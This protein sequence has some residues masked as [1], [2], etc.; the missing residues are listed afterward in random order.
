MKKAVVFGGC[1]EVGKSVVRDLVENSDFNPIVI[2]DVRERVARPFIKELGI[3][4]VTFQKANA[5]DHASMVEAMAGARVIVNTIG[6]FYEFAFLVAQAAL[7]AGVN[8]VDVC[9]DPDATVALLSLD[10]PVRRKGLTFLINMGWTP[11]CL[12]LLAKQGAE[13]MDRVEAIRVAWVQDI[14]EE[15]GIAPLMHWC[16]VAAGKVPTYRYG[17]WVE[18]LGLTEREEVEFPDPVGVVPVYHVGH[19][20]P[21]TLPRFIDAQYV[22]C[23]GGLIPPE[24]ITVSRIVRATGAAS[25]PGRIRILARV[26][27]PLLPVL[28]KIGGKT[29]GI[30]GSRV[31]VEGEKDGGPAKVSYGIAIRVGPT[32]GSSA[33]VG[34]QMIAAGEVTHHG[35]LPPEACVDTDRY[36]AEMAKRGLQVIEMERT[37]L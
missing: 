37:G 18:V 35:V 4:R 29:P 32:T 16:H 3:D 1:G 7:S 8:Y 36:F 25:T 33:A 12:N 21:V 6:P 24:N 34:A 11:G 31:D 26:F 30:T 14:G 19:P 15:I 5:H 27:M 17:R 20:E 13:Q 22:A 9:D 28:S 10:T 2:A 23:K